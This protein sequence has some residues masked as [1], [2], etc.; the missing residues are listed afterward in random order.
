MKK[1]RVQF[2]I[3]VAKVPVR[4]LRKCGNE[5]PA[6]FVAD[7]AEIESISTPFYCNLAPLFPK[8]FLSSRVK[9]CNNNKQKPDDVAQKC[10]QPVFIERLFEQRGYEASCHQIFNSSQHPT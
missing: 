5:K 1:Q 2:S 7:T 10:I 8:G 4:P 9:A 6:N 3:S